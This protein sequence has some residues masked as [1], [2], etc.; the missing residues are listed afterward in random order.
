MLELLRLDQYST[1]VLLM[2]FF[3]L[4]TGGYIIGAITDVIM[5]KRGYGPIGNGSLA[6]MGC[7]AGIYARNTYFS[8]AF[9]NDLAVT[10]IASG[11]S[12]TAMLLIFGVFKHWVTD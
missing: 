6:I 9:G 8:H 11:A 7:F 12:A 10:A 4:G 2:M 1:D 5:Q 3:F